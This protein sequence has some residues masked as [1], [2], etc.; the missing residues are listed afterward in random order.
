MIEDF[1]GT[2]A[3]RWEFITDQV[4]GGVSTGRV[5][6]EGDAGQTVLHLQGAVSTANNGG[7]IQA[8][9]KLANRLPETAQ[10]LELKVKGNGQIY[11]IHARTR[12][13]ILP[14]NFYQASFEVTPEWTVVRIPFGSFK[15]Q[16][17]L[18]SKT[19]VA[20]AVMSFAVVAF[21]RDHNADVWVAS[22]GCY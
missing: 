18:L 10:G 4:M 22:L 16:G 6:L 21:G 15:P 19:L 12:G 8:R 5:S 1:S 17:R 13:T 9:L 20:E 14:W 11:Y 2:P 3:S 7:F